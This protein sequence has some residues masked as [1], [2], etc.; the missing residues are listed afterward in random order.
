MDG[1]ESWALKKAEH[2]RIDAFKMWCWRRLLR[3]PWIARR[4]NQSTLKEINLTHWKEWY[5]SWSSNTLATWLNELTHWKRPWCW[6]RRRR[7]WQRMRW[8]GSITDSVDMNLG[9]LW[10]IL[11]DR[12]TWHAVVHGVTKIWTQ[13][14]DWTREK[15]SFL[16]SL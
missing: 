14:S 9:E 12:D 2:Q 1:Y 11:R 8:L 7:G 6:E 10:E 13:L 5:W 16:N 4:S 3:V 15:I